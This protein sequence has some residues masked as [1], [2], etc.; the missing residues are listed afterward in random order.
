MYAIGYSGLL[1]G[2]AGRGRFWGSSRLG[3]DGEFKNGDSGELG[4]SRVYD[5][6]GIL[7][8]LALCARLE[9]DKWERQ[10]VNKEPHTPRC[11]GGLSVGS[12]KG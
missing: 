7:P 1:R 4:F 11:E 9:N 8:L 3:G 5:Y 6:M 12:G 10:V 2:R